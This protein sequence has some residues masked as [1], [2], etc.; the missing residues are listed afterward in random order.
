MAGYLP[1]RGGHGASGEAMT[2]SLC[3]PHAPAGDAQGRLPARGASLPP[4][5]A[6]GLCQPVEK[7]KIALFSLLLALAKLAGNSSSIWLVLFL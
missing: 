3:L 5:V 6:R 1:L 4:A 7:Q 2:L